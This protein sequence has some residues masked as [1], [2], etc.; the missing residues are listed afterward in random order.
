MR[1]L[2]VSVVVDLMIHDLDLALALTR[3]QPVA[4]EA[5]GATPVND[6]FDVVEA[7]ATFDDGFTARFRASRVAEARER[8]MRIVYPSGEVVVDFLDADVL[9]HHAVS[10]STATIDQTPAGRDP[11]GA[12]I[13]RSSTPCAA[14]PPARSPAPATAPARSTWRWRSSRPPRAADFARGPSLG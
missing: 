3:A 14:R 7:E 10:R 8:T 13:A 12:S 9:Q 11:L 6:S 5:E 2:D 4:V 1:N